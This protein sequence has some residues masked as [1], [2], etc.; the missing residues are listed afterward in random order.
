MSASKVSLSL[1][2]AL[3]E[4]TGA[5]DPPEIPSGTEVTVSCG[6]PLS[7][8]GVMDHLLEV[9]QRLRGDRL[10]VCDVELSV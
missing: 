9:G 4:A 1:P 8:S 10:P 7:S 6:N 5:S 3:E 2:F